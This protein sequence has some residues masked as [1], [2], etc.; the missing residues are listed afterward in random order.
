MKDSEIVKSSAI[1]VGIAERGSDLPECE[2]SLDELDY[3][4][5]E[6][7]GKLS[8]LPNKHPAP[9]SSLPLLVINEGKIISRNLE[10]L[11]TNENDVLQFIEQKCQLK[12]TEVLT[13]DGTGKAY[14]KQKQKIPQQHL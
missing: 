10:F 5:F 11:K 8:A 7:N 2:L 13:V 9:C 14:L 3:A 6:S 12:D 1:I 4:V